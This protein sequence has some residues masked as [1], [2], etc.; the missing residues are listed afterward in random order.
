MLC[1]YFFGRPEPGAG[2]EVEADISQPGGAK[3]SDQR[4]QALG[5]SASGNFGSGCAA[6]REF[7]AK[8]V[9][10]TAFLVMLDPTNVW[11]V[12]L[13][14]RAVAMRRGCAR[15]NMGKYTPEKNSPMKRESFLLSSCAGCRSNLVLVSFVVAFFNAFAV[16]AGGGISSVELR[17]SPL[18]VR[19]STGERAVLVGTI[20]S[21][22]LSGLTARVI[23]EGWPETP[24]AK[25]GD[26]P[27]GT[28][29]V[30]LEVPVFSAPA[31]VKVRF[32]S[33]AGSHEAGPFEVKPPKRWTIYLT[34]HTHTDI[35]YTRPQTEILPEHLRYID[36]ALDFCDLTENYPEDAKFRW[37]CETGWAVREYLKRRPAE[38]IER[39]KRRSREGRIEVT[40][41]LL[42]MSEIASESSLAASLEFIGLLQREF[43]PVRTAMQNDVNGAAWCLVDYLSQLGV[44]YITMGINQTRS[45]LPFDKPTTFWWESPSG[46]RLLAYRPDH[47]MTANFWHIEQGRLD[48]FAPNVERYIASLE[49]RGYPFDRIGVQFS[50]YFT[51]N[52]PPST[53]ACDLVKEWNEKYASPRLRLST[54]QEFLTWVQEKHAGDLPVFRVA[55]PDWW[56]DGFGS[57]ARETAAARQTDT[58]MQMSQAILAEAALLGRP[59]RSGVIERVS[60]IQDKIF[61]YAEH[62]YGAAESID[63]PLAE[64]TQVQWGEKAAYVWEAVKESALLREEA[65]GL[66]QDRL[67]RSESPSMVVFNTLNWPRSGLVRVFID[68]EILPHDR[69]FRIID[70]ETGE[71]VAAQPLSKRAEGTWWVIWAKNVPSF[72]FKTFRIDVGNNKRAA[73][74]TGSPDAGNV[75]NE[76]YKVVVDPARG[77]VVS[78]LDKE[79]G[80]ELVDTNSGWGLGQCIYEV[81][82]SGRDMKPDAFRRSSVRNVKMEPGARGPIWQSLRF[83]ASMDGCDTNHGVRGEIRLYNTEKRVEFHFTLRKL[84]VRSPEAVYVAFPFNSPGSEMLY[85]AQGGTVVPGKDQLPGSASDWQTIQNFI[86]VRDSD[87]Q[88]VLGS[89]TI[90]LVQLGD[91]NL[92]KWQ[93]VTRV[94][95]PHVY[96]WVMNN[97]W[98]TNFRAEQEG[99]L[100]FAYYLTSIKD[101]AK[102]SATRFGWGSRVP[103]TARVLPPGKSRSDSLP[104][105][106]SFARIDAPNLLVVEV[107]PARSGSAV[108]AL[109][110]EL[111]G[112]PCVLGAGNV[113]VQ[114]P[115]IHVDEVN[116]IEQT[117][118]E[119]VRRIEFKPY[120]AKFVRL[121]M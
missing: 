15:A 67:P 119:D 48:A 93:R 71:A 113:H 108:V 87:S 57:A 3:S 52:S 92:G 84:A 30:R 66:I 58:S 80:R 97:Y 23:G 89:E 33:N 34:Q 60:D 39:L 19:S 103:M 107:R 53:I 115:I 63:D 61:F 18:I 16:A 8:V 59:I 46:N 43:G 10:R 38:Q 20:K 73:E 102:S 70:S 26:L 25:L 51:D 88:I 44:Q 22:A 99:D 91:F 112:Q 36:Y 24:V 49:E 12:A 109:I 28:N 21:D 96:S 121:R 106:F 110:R 79:L 64:N 7:R 5:L 17:S 68:H 86:A 41:M 120:E 82:T 56:T 32:E 114:A 65:L 9:A 1:L 118:R 29:K 2:E 111:D 94:D 47:Y 4:A 77:A 98:F 37:T 14:R 90:P 81:L 78:L 104:A 101:T 100:A 69:E 117:I 55:W 6:L 35:G 11:T 45:I 42:N 54:A 62:T 13:A 27:P 31:K 50:G 83:V 105:V 40:A 116:A 85:E 75:E 74:P 72:G 76:W 95:K